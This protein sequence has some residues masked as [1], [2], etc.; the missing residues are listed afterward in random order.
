MPFYYVTRRSA[1][2]N[3]SGNT[4]SNHF[5]LLT[6]ANQQNAYVVQIM[7]AV[8]NSTT[9]GSGFLEIVKQAAGGANLTGAT[10][11]TPPPMNPGYTPAAQTTAAHDSAAFTGY[12]ATRTSLGAVGFAQTGGHGGWVSLERDNAYVL[13]P[14]AGAN[15]NLE[16]DSFTATA[17]QAL[18]VSTQFLEG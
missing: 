17:S 15:G 2:T 5:R 13:N 14:N 10:A 8:R 7:A 9:A 18:E 1:T 6:I 11:Y 16:L 4:C 3:G 12:S